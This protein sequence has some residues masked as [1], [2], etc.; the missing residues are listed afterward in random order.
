MGTRSATCGVL[1]AMILLSWSAGA[2]PARSF[3]LPDS[4]Q[5]TCGEGATPWAE[6]PCAGTGQ[7]G[8]YVIDPID[9]TNNGNGTVTDNVTGLIWAGDDSMTVIN[10]FYASGTTDADINPTGRDYCGDLKV[11]GAT[12]WRLP[13]KKE[14]A[15][16]LDYSVPYPGP[17]SN[18]L[19]FPSMKPAGYWT[20]TTDPDSDGLMAQNAD[21]SSGVI[22]GDLKTQFKFARCVRGE[23][24]PAVFTNNGNGTVTDARTK[25][26]WQHYGA[27]LMTWPQALAYC[28]DLILAKHADWRLPNVKELESLADDSRSRPSLDEAF[29]NSVSNTPYWTSTTDAYQHA[30]AWNVTFWDGSVSAAYSKTTT[31]YVR[32]VRGGAVSDFFIAGRVATATGAG[33]GR[34]RMVLKQGATVVAKVWT[35]PIGGYVLSD[36]P[37][38]EYVLRPVKSGWTFI[39][40]HRHLT[41]AD[42]DLKKVNFTAVGQ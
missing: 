40:A 11:V 24:T 20:S 32:C 13:S 7:D 21:F 29:D 15:T 4:D 19:F 2:G 8:A 31:E 23:Q 41:V 38:G 10:W 16:L 35:K 39:K 6:I 26:V 12:D 28:R 18:S 30:Y 25:L 27:S 1:V 42:A 14:L 17:L 22:G 3:T 5:R 9:L 37:P 33:V 36:I 34:V